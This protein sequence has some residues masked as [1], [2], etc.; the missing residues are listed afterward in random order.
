M[1]E[2]QHLSQISALETEIS[3]LAKSLEKSREAY[4]VMKRSFTEQC[5]ETE[6]LR[7]LVAETRRVSP[8]L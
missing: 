4:E 7:N 5:S 1:T 2:K 8:S 6:K 3:K